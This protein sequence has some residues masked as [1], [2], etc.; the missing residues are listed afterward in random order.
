MDPQNTSTDSLHEQGPAAAD[1]LNEADEVAEDQ[2]EAK[3]KESW[4]AD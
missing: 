2:K 1:V 4:V 3:D